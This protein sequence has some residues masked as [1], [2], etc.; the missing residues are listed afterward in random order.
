MLLAQIIGF[1]ALSLVILTFQSNKRKT[2]QHLKIIASGLFFLHFALL[3]AWTGATMNIITA[4]RS[5]IFKDRFS[6]SWA[7]KTLWLYFFI[8]IFIIAGIFTWEGYRSLLPIV[9]MIIGTIAFWM[10]SPRQI[11]LLILFSSPCWLIYNLLVHSYAGII[12]EIVT[13]SSVIISMARFSQKA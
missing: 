11:R 7:G 1:L 5:Y 12:T 6:K 9:G 10:K 13:L 3:G 2:M 8:I 4:I